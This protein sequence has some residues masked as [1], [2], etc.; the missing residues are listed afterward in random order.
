VSPLAHIAEIKPR[1]VFLIYGEFEADHGQALYAAAGEPRQLW[2]VPGVGHGGY[3]TAYP[4][5]YERRV[6]EF[7]DTVFTVGQR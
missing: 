3:Q 6:I 2:I 1:P 7:F 5:E 4:D